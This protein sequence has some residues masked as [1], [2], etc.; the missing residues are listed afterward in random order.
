MSEERKNLRSRFRL[1]NRPVVVVTL[2]GVEPSSPGC[3]PG[4]FAVGPQSHCFALAVQPVG[5]EPTSARV[6]D[7]RLAAR[8]RLEKAEGTGLEPARAFASPAFQTGAIM[9]VGSPFPV[10][11]QFSSRSPR[12]NGSAFFPLAVFRTESGSERF[13][14]IMPA[15]RSLFLPADGREWRTEKR[16]G[17][18]ARRLL[19]SWTVPW[20][21]KRPDGTSGST[22]TEVNAALWL[23]P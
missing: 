23:R 4:V 19:C 11:Y 3:N 17:I 6:S 21:E 20:E 18:V 2:D 8:P 14:G 1:G 22:R 9:P 10:S 15:F 5:V 13:A 7:G 16:L 12:M